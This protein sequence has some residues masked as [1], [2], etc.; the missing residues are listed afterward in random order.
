M[1]K[2]LN[3][4]KTKMLFLYFSSLLIF[5]VVIWMIL[6][7]FLFRPLKEE[8]NQ[9]ITNYASQ[10]SSSVLNQKEVYEKMVLQLSGSHILI[11]CLSEQYEKPIEIWKAMEDISQLLK[12]NIGIMPAIQRLSVYAYGSSLWTDGLYI[13]TEEPLVKNYTV[14]YKWFEEKEKG[15]PLYSICCEIRGLYN[16]VEGFL[17]LSVNG[18][19]AFGDYIYFEENIDGRAYIINNEGLIIASSQQAAEGRNISEFICTIDYSMPEGNIIEVKNDIAIRQRIDDN[20]SVIVVIPSAYTDKKMQST[21]LIIGI[22]MLGIAL[23]TSFVLYQII[24]R[25]Y[26]TQEEVTNI[27]LQKQKFEVRSL[28]SQINPHFLYNTLGVMRWEALDCNSQR[29]VDMIDNLTVFYRRSL[30]KG[31]SFLTVSQEVELIKAYIAIQEERCDHCVKVEI[32]VDHEVED[33]VIPK[34][35]LQPLVENIWMH[36]NITKKG[37][38]YIGISVHKLD[39]NLLQI[40]VIDNGSGISAEHLEQIKNGTDE[41]SR[42]IGVSY[43]RNI[44]QFYYR[45]NFVYDIRSKEGEGTRV[46]LIVPDKIEVEADFG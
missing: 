30:N 14:N 2:Q 33:V 34:M 22:I 15:L 42:G 29:L 38:Q 45:E 5:Y 6:N 26:G 7:I 16:S 10:I 17:K 40:L 28:E 18:Q 4:T 35:I 13:F 32:E 27:K 12:S 31:N 9:H 1:N 21:Y 11:E 24:R 19:K 44:L 8:R 41:D 25:W 23:V 39:Q 36:G 37:K 43:I 20:W 46:S 3:F